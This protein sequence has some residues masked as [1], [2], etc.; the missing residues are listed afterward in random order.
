MTFGAFINSLRPS[1]IA[2]QILQFCDDLWQNREIQQVVENVTDTI[3]ATVSQNF[4][5]AAPV[6][7]TPVIENEALIEPIHSFNHTLYEW[8]EEFTNFAMQEP[9]VFSDSTFIASS[10]GAGVVFGGM[11]FLAHRNRMSSKTQV[12]QVEEAPVAIIPEEHALQQVVVEALAVE[13]ANNQQLLVQENYAPVDES[14][15]KSIPAIETLNSQ[16]SLTQVAIHQPVLLPVGEEK[17]RADLPVG[18]LMENYFK[19]NH[20]SVLKQHYISQQPFRRTDAIHTVLK[21]LGWEIL[22]L[23]PSLITIEDKQGLGHFNQVLDNLNLGHL[24]IN[25]LSGKRPSL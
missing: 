21:N 24:K 8:I 23:G 4:V 18:L 7:I 6:N 14:V 16:P 2:N 17:T 13:P 11:Y 12:T 9:D 22:K 20:E 5:F 10:I 25:S 3:N 15:M 1:E 19:N